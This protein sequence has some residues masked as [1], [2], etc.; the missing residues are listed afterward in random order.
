MKKILFLIYVILF[1]VTGCSVKSNV[2]NEEG[3][4]AVYK[5]VSASN[6]ITQGTGIESQDIVGMTDAMVRD[7]VSNSYLVN[8]K[9][10]PRIIIDSKYFKNQ[11]SSIINKNLITERLLINLNRASPGRLVFLDREDI[12]MVVDERELKRE[13][14]ISTG[15]LGNSDKIYG[16]DFRLTG[17]I[18]S[19]DSL[20][21]SSG[22]ES[23]YHQI[24]FKLIDLETGVLVWTN[25]YEFKKS[26]A[27]NVIYR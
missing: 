17:K 20:N 13:G 10:P 19:L 21:K 15:N 7:L 4:P 23:K 9:T 24:S 26:A 27:S 1:V 22:D 6:Q 16:A 2:I 3:K 11:S 5:D 12:E 8:R 25:T 18:M 14:M